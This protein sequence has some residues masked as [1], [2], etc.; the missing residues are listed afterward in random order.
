MEKYG[1]NVTYMQ[2]LCI[3]CTG[4]RITATI[5]LIMRPALFD[6]VKLMGRHRKNYNGRRLAL[7][8]CRQL[9]SQELSDV[10]MMWKWQEKFKVG[11]KGSKEYKTSKKIWREHRRSM[12]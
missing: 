2:G 8:D 6:R 5:L 7:D 9:T 12:E 10:Y 3:P 1:D 11:R 4:L